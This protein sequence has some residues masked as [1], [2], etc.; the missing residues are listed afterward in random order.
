[1]KK[2]VSILLALS[3]TLASQAQKKPVEEVTRLITRNEAE[4][5][6]TFLAA[7]EMRGRDTGSP[8]IEIAANYIAGYFRQLGLKPAPGT[9]GYFQ[10]V[11]FQKVKPATVVQFKVQDQTFNVKEDITQFSGGDVEVAGEIVFVGY[12]SEEDFQHADVKGKV[13]VAF[14]GKAAE[15]NLMKAFMSDAPDKNSLAKQKGAV[16]LVE[17][18]ATPGIP[19][20]NIAQFLSNERMTLKKEGGIPHLWMKNSD[21]AV[22][23]ALKETKKAS[24]SLKVAGTQVSY[25]N[26]KNVAAIVEGTDPVLK[27]E[28]LI[29]SA[30]YDHVGVKVTPNKPDSIYNGTRDN[31]L[32]TVGLMETAKFF[33]VYPPKRSVLLLA[34]TGEEKG[35]LGSSWYADHPLIPLKQSVFNFNCDGAGYN[36]KTVATVIGLE[37]T[38]A[39]ADLAKGCEAFGLKAGLDPVPEQNLYERSDNFS[40]AAKGIPAI[41]FAPGTKAFDAELLKYYHQPE[42]EVSSIDFDY[43]LKYYR[44][45]VYTNYLLANAPKAPTWKSGDKFEQ[46]AKK[47]YSGK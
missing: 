44:A 37:R 39:E 19:W 2:L 1:M 29:I 22:I 8:E 4:A 30:H 12:G 23:T 45:Y 6:L 15:N 28:Y 27:N 18:V 14:T 20:P 11:E 21:A 5:H 26:G 41:N 35:L 17:I 3:A 32:G 36:D 40:F 42:D 31:A 16:A 9:S 7:D 38:T 25:F 43:L 47:L 33:S 13:V 46:E 24:G 34:V 10:T